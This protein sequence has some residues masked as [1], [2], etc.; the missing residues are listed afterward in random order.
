MQPSHRLQSSIADFSPSA[1]AQLHDYFKNDTF[2]LL[3]YGS[4]G[5]GQGLNLRDN[6]LNVIVGVRKGGH[7][8]KE[9]LEDGWVEGKNL[10][11][12][13]EAATKVSRRSQLEV[14]T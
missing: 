3:G 8:W 11:S 13:E 7:S 10:F 2:A 5:H 12:I 14:P 9:A 6:G 4:Q 1:L